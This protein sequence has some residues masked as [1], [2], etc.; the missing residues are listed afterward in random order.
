MRATGLAR[1][2]RAAAAGRSVEPKEPVRAVARK[3]EVWAQVALRPALGQGQ[4][5][6]SG[7]VRSMLAHPHCFHH[8]SP[9]WPNSLR[10][11]LQESLD[12]S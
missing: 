5:R 12:A 8:R 10:W 9:Y 4:G 11:Q 2:L 7:E 3:R 6:K 1:R